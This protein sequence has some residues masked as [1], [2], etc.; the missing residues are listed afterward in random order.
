MAGTLIGTAGEMM[1]DSNNTNPVE[2][3]YKQYT[4]KPYVSDLDNNGVNYMIVEQHKK[5]L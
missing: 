1:L 2:E 3:S 5:N 4:K